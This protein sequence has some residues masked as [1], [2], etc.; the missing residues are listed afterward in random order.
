MKIKRTLPPLTSGKKE[1]L[2]SRGQALLRQRVDE[3]FQRRK[4]AYPKRRQFKTP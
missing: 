1:P 2:N 3:A 4:L